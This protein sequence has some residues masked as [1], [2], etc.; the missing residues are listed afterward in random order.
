MDSE[1]REHLPGLQQGSPLFTPS[2]L[3]VLAGAGGGRVLLLLLR[4]PRSGLPV[5]C[6]LAPKICSFFP[7]FQQLLFYSPSPIAYKHIP[8]SLIWLLK[9]NRKKKSQSNSHSSLTSVVIAINHRKF[10][11]IQVG[12]GEEKELYKCTIKR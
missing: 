12:S 5:I 6:D 11:K 3:G 10:K 8:I 7:H 1:G 9:G 4:A 2:Q